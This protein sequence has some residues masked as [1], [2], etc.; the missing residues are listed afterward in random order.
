MSLNTRISQI[1]AQKEDVTGGGPPSAWSSSSVFLALDPG[2]TPRKALVDR[3]TSGQSLTKKKKAVGERTVDFSY[4]IDFNGSGALGTEPV[5][6][7]HLEACGFFKDAMVKISH[8]AVSGG[9]FVFGETVTGG[10]SGATG[11]MV[12]DVD[13]SYM[14]MRG[15]SVTPFASGEV[16]TGGTSSA[17]ATT[18]STPGSGGF[19][20]TPVSRHTHLVPFDAASGEVTVGEVV[21]NAGGDYAAFVISKDSGATGNAILRPI[22]GE[23]NLADDDVLTG[24]TSSNTLTVDA[25]T[26]GDIYLYETPSLAM[27]HELDGTHRT[28]YG[29]RG[30]FTIPL[31]TGQNTRINFEM[32]GQESLIGDTAFTTGFTAPSTALLLFQNAVCT[33]DSIDMEVRS[34][35]INLQGTVSPRESPAATYGVREYRFADRAPQITMDPELLPE[36]AYA[37]MA[38]WAAAT[39]AEFWIKF[40]TAGSGNAI[41]IH[42]PKLQYEEFS[43]GDADG[44]ATAEWTCG[45]TEDSSGDDELLIFMM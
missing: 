13:G 17:T 40:G 30:T 15:T 36:G 24:Q 29:V 33:A 43:D 37:W 3:V 19:A 6:G 9:P 38:A 10:T 20:Y 22:Y 41:W 5:W 11:L 8:G 4:G 45:L 21:K 35:E 25:P 18:S 32:S 2:S 14:I 1:H 28:A 26:A 7:K 42:A 12:Y 34:T 23:S 39:T 31:Q 16:L 27:R 44:K